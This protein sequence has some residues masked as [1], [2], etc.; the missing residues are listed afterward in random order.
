[1]VR[2]R[3]FCLENHFKDLNSLKKWGVEHIDFP[4]L[5]GRVMTSTANGNQGKSFGWINYD[6]IVSGEEINEHFKSY[7]WEERFG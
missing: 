2:T 3:S 1:L 6:L 4:E 5:Q 7:G